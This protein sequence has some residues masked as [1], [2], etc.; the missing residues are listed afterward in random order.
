MSSSSLTRCSIR[1]MVA[2]L[3]DRPPRSASLIALSETAIACTSCG[4][5]DVRR[6]RV[7]LQTFSWRAVRLL[8]LASI[9]AR[10]SLA[11]A[12]STETRSSSSSAM[13]ALCSASSSSALTID[14]SAIHE[15]TPDSC[16]WHNL[17]AFCAPAIVEARPCEES[18]AMASALLSA[19][20]IISETTS[21]LF[22]ASAYSDSARDT[23]SFA[24]FAA[25]SRKAMSWFAVSR[26]ALSATSSPF[27]ASRAT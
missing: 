5:G 14:E 2:S 18:V 10:S 8:H 19:A 3:K 26:A 27:L 9:A 13:R 22:F 11:A 16:M 24:V 6:S 1:P 20:R 12:A 25:D 7:L 21:S 17:A 23:P 4:A 15:A